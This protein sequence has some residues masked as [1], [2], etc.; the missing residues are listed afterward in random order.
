M[1]PDPSTLK[2]PSGTP[3][4]I[5]LTL[6]PDREVPAPLQE[7]WCSRRESPGLNPDDG[8]DIETVGPQI[9]AADHSPGLGGDP[10]ES[11]ARVYLHVAHGQ[12]LGERTEHPA[13]PHA[14]KQ[15]LN[16]QDG[17][18]VGHTDDQPTARPHDSPEFGDS[19]LGLGT[20]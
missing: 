10:G 1:K 9:T 13:Q 18:V 14:P 2:T 3:I 5:A 6:R 7:P 11:P 19:A 8:V 20:P 15:A 16:P 4:F 17:Q 12:P